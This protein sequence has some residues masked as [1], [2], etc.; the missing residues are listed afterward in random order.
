V[1]SVLGSR[2][3]EIMVNAVPEV[4]SGQCEEGAAS[5]G[6][7]DNARFRTDVAQPAADVASL[8]GEGGTPGQEQRRDV[9]RDGA[10]GG[11]H[12]STWGEASVAD[13]FRV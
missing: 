2:A 10:N 4:G 13:A 7:F 11:R 8:A 12:R 9:A 6:V 3:Q 1:K 5:C